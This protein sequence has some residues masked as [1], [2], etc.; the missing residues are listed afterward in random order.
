MIFQEI[1]ITE[2]KVSSSRDV[3]QAKIIN[4]RII[5]IE[6]LGALEMNGNTWYINQLKLDTVTN[7]PQ[8]SEASPTEVYFHGS[9]RS[10]LHVTLTQDDRATT[11]QN[12]TRLGGR[13]KGRT[14]ELRPGLAIICFNSELH[15]SPHL[16]F[17]WPRKCIYMYLPCIASGKPGSTIL[18]SAQKQ[19]KLRYQ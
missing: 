8:I 16:M 12:V 14:E 19:K 2:Q 15:A 17:H 13:R 6:M 18:L 5:S 4:L 11:I 7:S 10:L 3:D 1:R 9:A